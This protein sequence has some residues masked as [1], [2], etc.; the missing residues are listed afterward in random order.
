VKT[1]IRF[2]QPIVLGL[3]LFLPALVS[4]QTP[5]LAQ[6][7][8]QLNEL[9]LSNTRVVSADVVAANSFAPPG[10][11]NQLETPAFCRLVGV[12]R[13]AVNFE[14]W[15][16]LSD[17]NGKFQVV[18]NGGMAGTISYAAMARALQRNYATASTDTGHKAGPISFDASWAS[19]RPDLIEDFGHRALHL[20]TVNGKRVVNALYRNPPEYS[21]YVGCSKGGQQGLMEAQRYPDDFDGIIAGDPANDWTRFYAGAHLW[22]SQAMLADQEAWI[23]PAKLK[24]LGGAVNNACDALDGIEDGILMNPLACNFEPASLTCPA[25][26]DSNSCL[27]TRQVSAVEKIWSGVRNSKGELIYPGLVPGGEA[28]PGGWSTWVTGREPFRSLHWLGG[29]GFFRWFV[30]DNPDWDFTTFNYDADLEYALRKVGPAVDAVDP[31]LTPMRDN[32]S[33]LIV[34]HGWSDPDISPLASINYYNK[35][36]DFIQTEIG[37]GDR[38]QALESTQEFYRLFMVP[39]MAHCAGGP[40]PDRFDALNALE[41]WVERGQA[42]ESIIASKAQNG[43]T[44]RTRPLCAYPKVAVY[45][46]SGSTDQAENFYC[47]VPD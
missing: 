18:G 40:G 17:W 33:K 5:S 44:T 34:Y 31:D 4:A 30:F 8:R 46:G 11:D 43:E 3:A 15:L 24:T 20:T 27:T 1:V 16:P 2:V 41:N 22:Y 13:P 38:T 12:T 42:P 14:V 7:C 39:G 6:S 23:P 45:D 32:G 35:V 19:G 28:A 21:Y 47:A 36:V 9:V 26:S 37:S 25:G 29:E 10:N